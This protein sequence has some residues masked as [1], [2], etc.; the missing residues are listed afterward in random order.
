[1]SSQGQDPAWL[2]PAVPKT[3]R[4]LGTEWD[5]HGGLD[6]AEAYGWAPGVTASGFQGCQ[7]G[8]EERAR[9]WHQALGH[10]FTG[11]GGHV[12]L[13]ASEDS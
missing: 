1:M 5:T 2:V 12:P 10:W 8:S 9:R 13:S 3:G 11:Q 4:G 6:S 7:S